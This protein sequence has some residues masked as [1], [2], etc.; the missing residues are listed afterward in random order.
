V[1]TAERG[2]S[3]MPPLEVIV[4]ELQRILGEEGARGAGE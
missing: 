2:V 4:E 1:S 3:E